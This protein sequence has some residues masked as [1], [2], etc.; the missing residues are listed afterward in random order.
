MS[1]IVIERAASHRPAALE[2][3]EVL[4]ERA[5]ELA[6]TDRPAPRRELTRTRRRTLTRRGVIWLGQTC[7][8]RCH[9]CY[10]LDRIEN[11]RH[12]E[13]AFMSLEKAQHICRTLREVYGNTA[14]D[15]QG[16][17]PTLWPPIVE[18][19]RFCRA[20]GL[21]PTIITNGLLLA[22]RR[23]CIELREAG[24]RDFLVS[25]H[26]LGGLHDAVVGL[27][28][29][30]AKQM[31]ALS[32]LREL[33]IPFRFNC[34]MSKAAAPQLPSLAS[35]AIETGALAVNFLAFNPFEDQ[36]HSGVRTA[37]NVPLYSELSGPLEL[38]LDR[39][40]AAG[41]EANVR[42]I[43]L[44]MVAARHRKSMYNF[45][46]LPYDRH[47]WDFHSW[48]WTGLPPQRMRQ[49]ETSPP[50]ALEP[51]IPADGVRR[52]SAP[53][54]RAI[55][56]HPLLE[57]ATQRVWSALSHVRHPAPTHEQLLWN[58]AEVRAVEHCGYRRGKACRRC[59]LRRICDGFQ[60]DY[61]ALF[62]TAEARAVTG[63][64]RI[65]H[66]AHF[67]REQDRWVEEE[68]REWALP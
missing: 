12:P 14:V 44:C 34:V 17:E 47:E 41:V 50:F 52:W 48:S 54:R 53:L 57:R 63:L 13:H 4:L 64:G 11:A 56:G 29:A 22:D 55:A 20:I 19:V 10:F 38:A 39:L 51:R 6:H 26:G 35:L 60:G 67:I 27:Q 33:D 49:G 3:D 23:R 1:R 28:G 62:G 9:F 36:L 46:Q 43:P 59:D 18:L 2:A 25:V 15:L 31:R 5:L 61:A 16:G 45:K 32:N 42:Y 24:L 37:N 65:D 40:E 66:P 21:H 7:N 58:N 30:A 68:D 8:L